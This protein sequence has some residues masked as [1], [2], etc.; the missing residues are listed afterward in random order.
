M[1]VVNDGEVAVYDAA[2]DRMTGNLRAMARPTLR[3]AGIHPRAR[4]R[5]TALLGLLGITLVIGSVSLGATERALG[6]K[7][8]TFAA[9]DPRAMALYI[10][11]LLAVHV[12]QRV[13][14]H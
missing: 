6:G 10:A 11:M 9:A 8:P 2:R 4:W 14:R 13:L 7:P 12:A 1:E 5:E 3:F